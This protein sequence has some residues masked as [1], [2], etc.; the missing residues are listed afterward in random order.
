MKSPFFLTV[1]LFLAKTYV[2]RSSSCQNLLKEGL[3]TYNIKKYYR[4]NMDLYGYNRTE[5]TDMMVPV[6]SRLEKAVM[7]T[8]ISGKILLLIL[9]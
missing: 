1:F 2:L 9:L 4:T 8:S 6:L 3:N 5:F 7:Q